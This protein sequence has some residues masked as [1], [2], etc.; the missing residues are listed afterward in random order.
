MRAF[1]Q[2][3][4]FLGKHGTRFLFFGALLG[5]AVPPLAALLNPLLVVFLLVP[6]VLA[7][8]RLDWSGFRRYAHRP[9][10]IAFIC[11]WLLFVSPLAMWGVLAAWTAL[12]A[13]VPEALRQGLILM[14]AVSP[15]MSCVVLSLLIG[16][17]AAL[18]MVVV[19]LATALVPFTL[20]PFALWLLGL[21]IDISLGT[22]MLRL[23]AMV[24]VSFLAAFAIRA[25]VPA[26]TLSRNA[27]L[28]DGVSVLN[29]VLFCVAI[30]HGVTGVALARPG[31]ALAAML[32]V[33]AAN[34][35]LQIAGTLLFWR[36]GVRA[37]LTV[38]LLTG[39][40]NMGLVMVALGSNA[41]FDVIVFFALGQL[42]IYMLPGMLMPLYRRM[43]AR[44]P[45]AA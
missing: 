5:L 36:L 45:P 28:I 25:W 20:P 21:Q 40:C 31:Y 23:A 35:L 16:L 30:M 7:M 14:A 12:V 13:G 39:N 29:L 22:F 24:F 18:A 41:Q 6:L 34:L 19:L 38:G 8:V 32:A 17:D 3:F 11:I 33:F 2:L 43:L 1:G 44:Q 15:I 10:L 42:P 4:D 37:A 27:R 9:G 26:T